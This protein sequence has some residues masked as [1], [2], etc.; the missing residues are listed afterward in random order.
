MTTETKTEIVVAAGV[1]AFFLYLWWASRAR[2][3]PASNP[4]SAAPGI[5]LS[6]ASGQPLSGP[7]PFNIPAAVGGDTIAGAGPSTFDLGGVGVPSGPG[8]P[9]DC[10][11]TVGT[12]T[13]GPQFGS[14]TDLIQYLSSPAAVTSSPP[15]PAYI[16]PVTSL[17]TPSP[18][19]QEF[20]S[21]GEFDDNI[22][23]I[24]QQ[25]AYI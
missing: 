1:A 7:S 13:S 9:G 21:Q 11:C 15:A 18:F 25:L 3:T 24:Q 17:P 12:G 20:G 22:S 2:A 4:L 19:D 5:S 8:M 23:Q 6:T 16:P 10:G 14:V